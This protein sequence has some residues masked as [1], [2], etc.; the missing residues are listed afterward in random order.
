MSG[1]GLFDWLVQE[2]ARGTILLIAAWGLSLLIRRGAT[3]YGMW[4]ATFALLAVMALM[5]FGPKLRT[6]DLWPAPIS[7]A[8]IPLEVVASSAPLTDSEPLQP[9]EVPTVSQARGPGLPGIAVWIWLVGV[10]LG[11]LRFSLSWNR[12]RLALMDAKRVQL[13]DGEVFESELINSPVTCGIFRPRIL[14][15]AEFFD[16]PEKDQQMILQHERAHA[17][18]LDGLWQVL[19]TAMAVLHWPNPLVWLARRRL[20]QDREMHADT[21][22]ILAG[23]SPRIYS[24]LLLR[25]AA[26]APALPHALPMARK[27]SVPVRIEE[28]FQVGKSG[29]VALG[30]LLWLCIGLLAGIGVTLGVTSLA[31]E[32]P[33]KKQTATISEDEDLYTI[34]YRVPPSFDG[35]GTADSFA[36]EPEES[37]TVRKSAQE[38][39]EEVGVSFP[40]GA[41]AV[42]DRGQSQIIVRNLRSQLE[43][44]EAYVESLR[45]QNEKHVYLTCGTLIAEEE[46]MDTE[47]SEGGSK[48]QTTETG[49]VFTDPQFQVLGRALRNK[50]LELEPV[51]S[52]F[53]R[54]GQRAS[55]E[56]NGNP[57]VDITPYI[58]ADGI[59]IDLI[60]H[61]SGGSKSALFTIKDGETVLLK[62]WLPDGRLQWIFVTTRLVDPAGVPV[63]Q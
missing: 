13:P 31:S 41:S 14:V 33:A 9:I 60:L 63:S 40:E 38:I 10:G 56:N 51:V 16:W 11:A 22:V 48:V 46:E 6:L 36:T 53:T 7:A 52:L 45:G 2:L 32:Q 12:T 61:P 26:P 5:G 47:Y 49:A 24:E 30:P 58:G 23:A 3:R 35:S 37:S 42:Y 34:I 1:L 18:N 59:M 17:K 25:L 50:G 28:I 55:A 57:I 4:R 27:S 62:N 54:S 44:V 19:A 43:L 8:P 39:L 15:P 20:A 29:K 21:S